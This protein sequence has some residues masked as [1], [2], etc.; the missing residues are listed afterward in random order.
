[1]ATKPINCMKCKHYIVTWDG[2]NPKGCRLYGL[3]SKF[4]PSI[5]VLKES[6]KECLSF[7]R[8]FETEED[9]ATEEMDLND[10]SLW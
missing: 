8:K 3:K 4:L 10:D 1:M 7:E 9:D 5:L 6:G 2:N